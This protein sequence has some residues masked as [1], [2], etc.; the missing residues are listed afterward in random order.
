MHFLF[1]EFS[2]SSVFLFIF[3]MLVLNVKE[4]LSVLATI[5]MLFGNLSD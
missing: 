4:L 2:Y 5:S 3:Y 1:S